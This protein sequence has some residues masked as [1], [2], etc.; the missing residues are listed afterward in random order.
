MARAEPILKWAG[1]KRQLLQEIVRRLP[2]QVETYFE[3][4]IGGG[5]VFF[6]LAE[7]KRFRR[8]VLSD[9]NAELIELYRVVQTDVEP[10]IRELGKMRHSE[11]EYYRIRASKPRTPVRRAARTVYLN[12][13][14]YN[15]LYRVNRSGEFNVPFGRYVSPRICDPERL[16]A[17]AQALVGVRLEVADF[18]P[19]LRRATSRD[20]IYL[21]P[22]YV[23][24]SETARFAEYHAAQFDTL[25]HQR[26]ARVFGDLVERGVPVVLSNSDTPLTREL[27]SEF[28][29]EFLLA[30]RSINSNGTRR[31]PVREILAFSPGAVGRRRLE[32]SA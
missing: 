23:P 26:L 30:R 4:F 11:E 22:P 21:D 3:P 5:A 13:T 32:A 15:G 10:L 20:A 28:Q 29:H 6:E 25:A 7:Q 1:G 16:R 12:R 14:G 27:Y 18:E 2:D 17:V 19:M 31:G 9:Q 8:A 24:V